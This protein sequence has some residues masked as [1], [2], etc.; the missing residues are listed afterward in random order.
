MIG[1]HERFTESQLFICIG[2]EHDQTPF[3]FSESEFHRVRETRAIRVYL[4][5][6]RLQIAHD[7]AVDHDFN[8]VRFLW[9][10]LWIFIRRYD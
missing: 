4:F 3:S 10:Q 7:Q 2:I 8:R 1:A 5:F 9:V 6:F